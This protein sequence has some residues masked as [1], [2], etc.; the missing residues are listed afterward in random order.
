MWMEGRMDNT[1]RRDYR[2]IEVRL[3]AGIGDVFD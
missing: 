3:I 2:H 1:V